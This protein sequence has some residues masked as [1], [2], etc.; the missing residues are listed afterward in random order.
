MKSIRI[1]QILL[2]VALVIIAILGTVAAIGN[3]LSQ[4]AEPAK[5]ET[6]S[7]QTGKWR[8]IKPQEIKVNPVKLANGWLAL[9]AGKKNDMNAMTVGWITIGQIW[10]DPVAMVYVSPDR[11]TF[12][13]MERNDYFTVTAFPEEDREKLLILGTRSGRD[14]DKIKDAGLTVEYT[15]LGNPTFTNGCLMLECRKIY[16]QQIDSTLIDKT[17]RKSFYVDYKQSVHHL[18]V[19]AIENVWVKE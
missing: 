4:S 3:R 17:I 6:H 8:K 10:S 7:T 13:F 12:E 19:G 18:Y 5:T 14:G 15:K 2:V 16:S 9:A 1:Y 11:Y